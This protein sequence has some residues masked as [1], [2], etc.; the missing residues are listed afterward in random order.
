MS[1]ASSLPLTYHVG[2]QPVPGYTLVRELGRGAMG[3]VW[4]AR[5]D[6]GFERALKVI[7]LQ[8]RGGRK[9]YRGLRTV[10]QRKLL[11]GNLL[12][13][14][15]Y[16][17]KDADGQFVEDTDEL[18][19]SDSFFFMPSAPPARGGAGASSPLSATLPAGPQTTTLPPPTPGA[20]PPGRPMAGT[21]VDSPAGA[22]SA[23]LVARETLADRGA[24]RGGDSVVTS[25][26]SGAL[27]GPHRRPVQL[28]VAMELGHQTLDDRLKQCRRDRLPGI[29]A[30]ELLSYMEQAARG[31][32]YLHREGIVHRDV[33]PQNIMLVG[34]V[35]KVCDYGLVIATDTDLRLTSNA[36]TPLYASPEAVAGKPVTGQSDQYSLAVTY[37]ELRTGRTPYGSET[38]AAVFAA[39]DTGKYDLSRIRN[40]R[41]RAVLRRALSPLPQQRYESCSAFIRELQAAERTRS[42]GPLLAA[43]VV[44]LCL[45]VGLAWTWPILRPW[46][47]RRG[48]VRVEPDGARPPKTSAGTDEPVPAGNGTAPAAAHGAGSSSSATGNVA[49][50][51]GAGSSSAS[52]PT[53][54]DDLARLLERVRQQRLAGD[55]EAATRDLAAAKELARQPLE[56]FQLR[57]A[58]L[59]RE[60]ASAGFD[61]NQAAPAQRQHWLTEL[62]ELWREQSTLPL[63]SQAL[64][65]TELAAL[66]VL[67][68]AVHSP[69]GN[70]PPVEEAPAWAAAFAGRS[71]WPATLSAEEQARLLALRTALTE[72]LAAAT[73]P[74]PAAWRE[75]LPTI[76]PPAELADLLV[77]R[78]ERAA[79]TSEAARQ[80]VAADF[81]AA[82]QHWDLAADRVAATRLAEARAA[83]DRL[84]VQSLV[85]QLQPLLE[86]DLSQP[87]ARQRL[88]V[89]VR[90]LGGQPPLL[91]R[92]LQVDAELETGSLPRTRLL[93]LRQECQALQEELTAGEP[94]AAS[95]WSTQPQWLPLARWL[96]LRVDLQLGQ[97]VR[98]EHV[99]LLLAWPVDAAQRAAWQNGH[100]TRESAR[101]LVALADAALPLQPQDALRFARAPVEAAALAQVRDYL[102]QAA[103]LGFDPPDAQ[104]LRAIVQALALA[105]AQPP[106]ASAEW[107]PVWQL[108]QSALNTLGQGGEIARRREPLVGYVAALAAA[109][110]GGTGDAAGDRQAVSRFAGL[111]R[112]GGWREEAPGSRRADEDWLVNVVLPGLALPPPASPEA[113]WGEDLALLWAAQGR[114]LERNGPALLRVEGVVPVAEGDPRTS[115]LWTAHAAY[116]RAWELDPRPAYAAGVGRTLL[117]LPRGELDEGEHLPLL[118]RLV[119]RHDPDAS[120]E[121]GLLLV[122]GWLARKQAY[123][124]SDRTVR[125]RLVQDALRRFERLDQATRDS[126]VYAI[127]S[128]ALC[129]ASDTCLRAAFW[130]PIQRADEAQQP[131][132]GSKYALLQ[133]ALAW[134]RAA[135]TD[136]ERELPEEAFIAEGNALED[137]AYYY[138]LTQHY[139]P[140]CRAFQNAVDAAGRER[141]AYAQMSLGRCRYRWAVD[142]ALLEGDVQ[143]HHQE[144]V[145]AHEALAAALDQVRPTQWSFRGEMLAWRGYLRKEAAEQGP[146][147]PGAG[148]ER[149][150]F[151]NEALSRLV[152]QRRDPSR[153][154]AA[155]EELRRRLVLLEQAWRDLTAAAQTVQ[156]HDAAQWAVYLADALEIG[157]GLAGRLR[158]LTSSPPAPLTAD[159]VWRQLQ[160]DAQT[161]LEY[162]R[163]DAR[164]VLAGRARSAVKVL[165]AATAAL[166]PP[167]SAKSAASALLRQWADLFSTRP[168]EAWQSERAAVLL[169]QAEYDEGAGTLPEILAA[170]RQ[171][172]GQ[173]SDA[174]VR[175]SLLAHC[176]RLEAD[177]RRRSLA[178]KLRS[179]NSANPQLSLAE[180][181]ALAALEDL[182]VQAL[183]KMAQ[184]T[185]PRTAENLQRLLQTPL[186][187][188]EDGTFE[189]ELSHLERLRLRLHVQATFS[190]A[191]PLR[192]SLFQILDARMWLH[193]NDWKLRTENSPLPAEARTTA[194]RVLVCLK[195]I[196]LVDKRADLDRP[197]LRLLE[198]KL[199]TP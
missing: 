129:N 55:L 43:G 100:R 25:A 136:P 95:L 183:E 157:A 89:V 61:P 108:A 172:A 86:A 135:Q 168:A 52:R 72:T 191:V 105:R 26:A 74:W 144:L 40:R 30:E 37:V 59:H 162:A 156:P 75:A 22:A 146:G 27:P 48:I 34:D 177:D 195:P 70:I 145:L 107:L 50:E 57:L 113:T 106:A 160:A 116:R 9:E 170:V 188:I 23:T 154:A 118:E 114:I 198:K 78:V 197:L 121:P 76:Y 2:D 8:E 150:D 185:D 173:M 3:V 122:G 99:A 4:L 103:A 101:W 6:R 14:I 15:D 88:E 62:D 139:E 82:V 148:G 83:L 126:D 94:P 176:L 92:L 51:A 73:D 56:L 117:K 11:H 7:N 80:A 192:Q 81:E 46:V 69:A 12:T 1:A 127:R 109:R 111:L 39:K 140:A 31:L 186:E 64:E 158:D 128:V 66:K 143:R 21:A 36:F 28:L 91:A 60:L 16:W 164:P 58:T 151:L 18:G 71:Q 178:D 196:L 167:S 190:S 166:S 119:Q 47:E 104:A 133:Q 153:K 115:C 41:V 125:D 163:T 182:Y 93:A 29:P 10:K 142:A 33:K 110:R 97:P 19:S 171:I 85:H 38:A 79:G 84:Q 174:A 45:G 53:E 137:L 187:R 132:E 5:T 49:G 175:Q 169:M 17:L 68:R 35:A 193:R 54:R 165:A 161:L 131:R 13:L 155:E 67:L 199:A 189:S 181:R 149:P 179:L 63:H 159:V 32:D 65:R 120:D 77:R 87:E 147:D 134:G 152:L 124:E 130:T 180:D 90:G 138:K 42:R 184:A 96:M 98:P 102:A 112:E 24:N 44:A 194:Q 141:S 20:S 123:A